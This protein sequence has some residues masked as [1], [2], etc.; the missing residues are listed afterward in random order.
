MD[1]EAEYKN[2][3]FT[4]GYDHVNPIT[5]ES[6][7]KSYVLI[8][9]TWGSARDEMHR[10]FGARWSHQYDRENWDGPERYG[11]TELVLTGQG[12][13]GLAQERAHAAHVDECEACQ[14]DQRNRV[15]AGLLAVNLDNARV[16]LKAGILKALD[17]P[18]FA[19]AARI[20][21]KAIRIS[22]ELAGGA[23]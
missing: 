21:R 16:A 20:L 12:E 7:G 1:I 9:G 14:E 5:G 4:F 6:L 13:S 10:R 22:D 11:L 18:T 19:E 3:A 2:Y 15:E 8:F 17:A 23:Q